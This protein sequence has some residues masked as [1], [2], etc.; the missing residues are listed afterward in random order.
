[1]KG[2]SKPS[3]IIIVFGFFFL[4]ILI[5]LAIGLSGQLSDKNKELSP[6]D[7]SASSN[8]EQLIKKYESKYGFAFDYSIN[9][10]TILPINPVAEIQLKNQRTNGVLTIMVNSASGKDLNAIL[11]EE[12][13]SLQSLS[14]SITFD[15][16]KEI[17]TSARKMIKFVYTI[18]LIGSQKPTKH[19]RYLIVE[20]DNV[21]I[22]NYSYPESEQGDF[23]EFDE[24]VKNVQ[25]SY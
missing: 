19:S 25:L 8:E 3:K 20:N 11:I 24:F 10:W 21:F 4:L 23:T 18:Q 16:E 6:A 2:Q 12:K 9:E 1:M 17:Q 15:E 22:F 5:G 14:T 7:T 13:N